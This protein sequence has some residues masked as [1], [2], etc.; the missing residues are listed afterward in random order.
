M[1]IFI[2]ELSRRTTCN[3]FLLILGYFYW[4]ADH[5]S[6]RENDV[7]LLLKKSQQLNFILFTSPGII[8]LQEIRRMSPCSSSPNLRQLLVIFNK[9][10]AS[11]RSTIGHG[12]QSPWQPQQTVNNRPQQVSL[13]QLDPPIEERQHIIHHVT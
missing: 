11:Q 4:P 6:G 13:L 3:A 12:L 1:I 10:H 5:C 9:Q 2:T 8:S 7:Q